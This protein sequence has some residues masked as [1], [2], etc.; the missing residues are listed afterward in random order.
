MFGQGFREDGTLVRVYAAMTDVEL[1]Q[2]LRMIAHEQDT[3]AA[4]AAAAVV[5]QQ[6]MSWNTSA[7]V[8]PPSPVSS[9]PAAGSSQAQ[10]Q[11]QGAAIER[12]LPPPRTASA[13]GDDDSCTCIYYLLGNDDPDKLPEVDL[14]QLRVSQ[15]PVEKR[16]KVRTIILARLRDAGIAHERLF[17]P[18]NLPEKAVMTTATIFFANHG[19]ATSAQRVLKRTFDKLGCVVNFYRVN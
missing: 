1:T 9:L 7:V 11:A 18:D 5:V 13:C 8:H 4:A 17:V 2:H 14:R 12:E 10:A 3:R 16:Y 15:I 6:P 19:V